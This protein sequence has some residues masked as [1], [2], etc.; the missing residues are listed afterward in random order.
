MRKETQRTS[1]CRDNEETCKILTLSSFLA[2]ALYVRVLQSH[3]TTHHAGS[4]MHNIY[5]Q[6]NRGDVLCERDVQ[7]RATCLDFGM[8]GLHG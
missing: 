3:E 7:A 1:T 4:L 8:T 5:V 2:V 6:V